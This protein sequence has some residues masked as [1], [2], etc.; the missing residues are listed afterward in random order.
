[1]PRLNNIVNSFRAGQLGTDMRGRTDLDLFDS[2]ARTITN[3]QVKAQ[4]GVKRRTGTVFVA[5]AEDESKVSTLIPFELADG[6]GYIIELSNLKARFYKANAQIREATKTITAIT[7]ANPAVVTAS[8]HGYNNGDEVYI[9]A[10]AGMIQLNGRWFTVANKTTNTF[11]LS[12]VNSSDYSTYTSAGTSAKVYEITTPWSDTMA[13][14]VQWAQDGNTLY[15]THSDKMVRK[16]TRTA[17]T[18]WSLATVVFTDGP[19]QDTNTSTTTLTADGTS[20]SVTITAS[21]ATF[22]ATDTSGSGGS[23]EIDRIVRMKVGSAAYGYAKI[24]AYSSATSVTATVLTAL[25]G[26][27]ATTDWKLGS[28]SSTTGFPKAVHFFEQRL[29]LAATSAEPNGVWGSAIGLTEDMTP[30]TTDSDALDY[31]LATRDQTSVQWLA[32][33]QNDLFC[34]TLQSEIN[35]TGGDAILKPASPQVVPNSFIGSVAVMPLFAGNS[36]LFVDRTALSVMELSLMTDAVTRQKFRTLDL[37]WHASDITSGGIM[38]SCY[39]KNP[40]NVAWFVLSGGTLAS[41]SYDRIN[42]VIAW[43][44]HE[45]GGVS[46][47]ATITVTDY[48]NIAVGTTITITKSDGTTVTFTSEA[49]SGSAPSGTNGWRPN[50]SNDTTA[51]NIFTAVNGHADFTVAN[52]ASNVVTILETTRAGSAPLKIATSDSTRLAATDEAVPI[53]E[54]VSVI[55]ASGSASGANSQVWVTVQRTIDGSTH[56]YV[57]YLD[58]SVYTD[59]TYVYS[60]SAIT[61]LT[62]LH[63]LEGNTVVVKADGS[64]IPNTNVSDGTISLGGTYTAVEAGL[65]YTHTLVTQVPDIAVSNNSM[66]G[67][68][69]RIHRVIL[70]LVSSLGS[71]INGDPIVYR[72]AGDPMDAAPPAYTGDKSFPVDNEWGREGTITITGHDP[73]AFELS[74]LITSANLNQE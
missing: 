70:R 67:M 31:T 52:P 7:K 53:V 51:D 27:A 63:H 19:Y 59:S 28:F 49:L 36:V 20:G 37:N 30:G 35:L 46:G 14:D 15:L 56:R 44:T 62:G 5:P 23:G 32:A 13:D 65:P 24:T 57:E 68:K 60:G 3:M 12:G 4:G 40:E 71:T 1:M 47:S 43:H 45:L 55:P 17:D 64:R 9:T 26:T 18:D 39:Q 61:S 21:A 22:A 34:G 58:T 11:E 25:G 41:L 2:S 73:Y 72:K 38:R 16:L 74:A 42:N 48:A 50:E 54:S 29:M 66:A 33:L 69:R 8:S 10:V 6:T